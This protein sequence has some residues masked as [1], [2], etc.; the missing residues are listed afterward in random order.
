MKL[1]AFHGCFSWITFRVM[2]LPL[3]YTASVASAVCALL[4]FVPTYAVALPGCVVLLAQ[5][6][7]LAAVLFFALHF[8]GYYF[9]D[10]AILEVGM[11]RRC[12]GV[13]THWLLSIGGCR[14]PTAWQQQRQRRWAGWLEGLTRCVHESVGSPTHFCP[15][16][17][18]L[19]EAPRCLPACL[20][21]AGHPWGA[22]L[23]FVPGD[24]GWHLRI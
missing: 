1:I 3:T 8:G 12:A 20:P 18:C 7:L 4:P 13:H 17:P 9:A 6:R 19:S 2:G 16:P 22:P 21:V 5:G 10:T 24:L 14:W 11:L 23:P 15:P